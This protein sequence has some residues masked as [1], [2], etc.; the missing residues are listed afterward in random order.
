MTTMNRAQKSAK[1]YMDKHMIEKIIGDMLNTLIHSRSDKP[2][3][4]MVLKFLL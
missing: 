4:F 1:E 2:L 3:I